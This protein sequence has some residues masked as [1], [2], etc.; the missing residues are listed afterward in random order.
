M[1]TLKKKLRKLQDTE[2]AKLKKV[3]GDMMPD[4]L[5]ALQQRATTAI[6]LAQLDVRSDVL[7]LLLLLLRPLVPPDCCYSGRS[8][9]VLYGC[10]PQDCAGAGSIFF[11]HAVSRQCSSASGT[12]CMGAVRDDVCYAV[13]DE[14]HLLSAS[15]Q[16]DEAAAKEVA[17][18]LQTLKQ[19]MDE[20]KHAHTAAYTTWTTQKKDMEEGDEG[21]FFEHCKYC[22]FRHLVQPLVA[23][24]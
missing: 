17:A 2:L 8:M 1:P 11:T 9:R 24:P 6:T 16:N 12:G 14:L 19:L 7:F 15:C 20:A 22:M 10:C 5:K 18:E 13:Q 21:A 3:V 4:T 23:V